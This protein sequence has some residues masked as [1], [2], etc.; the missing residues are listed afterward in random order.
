MADA[1]ILFRNARIVD[2]TGGASFAGDVAVSGD[3][4]TAVQ[5][6]LSLSADRTVDATGLVLAPGFID[7]HTHDD[8]IV[9]ADPLHRAKTSQ[10]V[11]TVVVGN[12]GVSIAPIAIDRRPPAPIDLIGGDPADFFPSF[13]A[14]FQALEG[15]PAAVNTLAFCGHS[16]LRLMAMDDLSRAATGP[17]IDAMADALNLAMR[18][19]A[20]GFTTGLEYPVANAAP[21]E[22]VIALAKVAASHGGIHATH[23]RN[24]NDGVFASLDETFRIGRDAEIPVVIS[25]HKC[26]GAAAHGRSHETLAAIEAAAARQPVGLD[27]YPY[28]ASSTMLD[29]V[30]VGRATKTIVAWSVPHPEFAARDLHQVAD[31][32]G[33]P[34][35]D[36]IEVLKPAGAIYFMMD[37]G[38][39]R[40][41]L[42]H[43]KSMIGSDGLP[44]DRHPHP[45]LWG[46]FPRVLG[47]Y[48]R[49]VGL[50]PL[51]TAIHKMTGLTAETFRIPDRG[52]IREGA[53][54]DLV[55]FDPQLIADRATF[56]QPMQ[57]AAG[58]VSVFVN[59]TAV[60]DANNATGARPG[61]PLKRNVH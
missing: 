56:E 37:E 53:F 4:I 41:I 23:M 16:S 31:E 10:G 7:A 22:E 8:R 33:L 27:V 25:H 20:A 13:E 47:H 50:F 11:T 29:P 58:I 40:R 44:H 21:T 35:A 17:E 51:E 28:V 43:R 14:Y 46:T 5:P 24:E 54:A 26:A 39:V 36:A 42:A 6:S 34:L 2:G 55:L 61:R 15:S 9:L 38:D 60:W 3:R 19:G 48:S 32:L 18:Q 59:G 30:R 52:V 12:C 45:R 57:P 1:D 49:E